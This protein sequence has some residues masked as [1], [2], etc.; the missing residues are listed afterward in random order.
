[1][2]FFYGSNED[3]LIEQNRLVWLSSLG[4]NAVCFDYR[5]YGFSD[6]QIGAAAIRDDA[7]RMFDAVKATVA[8][9]GSSVMVYGWSVGTQLALHVA[10]NRP[11]SGVI[12]QAPPASADATDK[13]SRTADVPS[14]VRWAVALKSD[15]D[16]RSIYQGAVEAKAVSAPLLIIEGKRD[17]TVPPAQAQAVF[18]ASPSTEKRIVFVDGADHNTLKF[19]EPPASSEVVAFLAGK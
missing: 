13:A 2:L 4:V 18:D 14:I 15:A 9:A 19:R 6:G 5:G 8:P 7:L 17:T 12:L 16:V 10:A 3:A 11:V 1:M